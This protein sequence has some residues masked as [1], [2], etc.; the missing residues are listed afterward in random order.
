MS[1]LVYPE[2]DAH[3][4]MSCLYLGKTC[5]CNSREGSGHHGDDKMPL[6]AVFPR[7]IKIIMSG[8]KLECTDCLEDG[9]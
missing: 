3:S 4:F 7:E 9:G 2:F 1:V 8:V 5:S 6:E